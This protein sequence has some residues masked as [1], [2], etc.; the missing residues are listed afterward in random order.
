MRLFLF[1]IGI[2]SLATASAWVI[3]LVFFVF[4]EGGYPGAIAYVP[5]WAFLPSV[6][7]PLFH[8]S[9]PVRRF[10]KQIE[11]TFL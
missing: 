3:S 4:G 5:M 7:V 10:F 8:R 9:R 6:F 2:V 1:L 11:K